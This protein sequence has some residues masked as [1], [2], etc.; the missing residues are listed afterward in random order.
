MQK[1]N[2]KTLKNGLRVVTIPMKDNPTVTVLVLVGTGSDYEDKNVNGISHFLEHMCFKGTI[3]RPTAQIIAHEL[4]SLGSV[5][6]AFTDHEMTG[7][8]A[9]ADSKHFKKIFDVIS[10]IYLNSTLPSIEIEK[11]KGVIVEEINMYE[12]MPHR[13]VHDVL[14][15][16]LYGDQPAGR[17][18][19]GTKEIVKSLTRDDFVTYKSSHYVSSATTIL[20]VG[21]ITEKE[22][23]SEVTKQFKNLPSSKK[24]KK[25][26]TKE[27]QV[28]P[29]ISLTYKATDQTHFVLAMRSFDLF[30]KR[31]MVL[32][33]LGAVLGAGMSSRLFIKLREEMGVAYYVNSYN[34]TSLDH[35]VFKIS[36]GVSNDR[37]KEV[38]S[39]ILKECKRL[40]VE[41]VSDKEL[42]KVKSLIIGNTKLAFEATDDIANYYGR[43]EIL[44]NEMKTIEE[45]AK[46]IQKVTAHDIQ[47]LAKIIFKNNGLNLALIGPF[48]EKGSF[49]KILKL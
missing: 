17:N 12:D 22:V 40:C 49:Q 21:N 45:K 18:I 3:K 7:Y 6:N 15:E 43:Q 34:D 47:K 26:K 23:I 2:K 38:I 41:K 24:S 11:E 30:D 20:V 28:T 31:N 10:D 25:A 8:Y 16:L 37:V 5:Y 35:G 46:E 44:K 42:T 36:A 4:D 48:K 29:Q 33:M 39:E 1:P 27:V 9:K 19:A 13:H 32:G 14:D